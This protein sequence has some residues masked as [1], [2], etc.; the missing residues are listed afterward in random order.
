MVPPF[1]DLTAI[2]FRSFAA[3]FRFEFASAAYFRD[4]ALSSNQ[5]R[6]VKQT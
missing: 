3:P 1:F 6:P 2:V 5:C 4:N